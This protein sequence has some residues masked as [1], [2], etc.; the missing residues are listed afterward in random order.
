MTDV[1]KEASRL[2]SSSSDEDVT[3]YGDGDALSER[4]R[5]WLSTPIGTVADNPSWGHNLKTF[6]FDPMNN[7]L[8]VSIELAI[9]EKLPKDIS[10]L[11]FVGI[12][13]D[14][15]EI[16]LCKILIRHQYGDTI[17]ELKL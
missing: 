15:L 14:F 10:D 8:A 16:D 11:I 6:K 12:R 4:I 2:I 5:E 9:A 3:K 1:I 13:V 17:T 7:N